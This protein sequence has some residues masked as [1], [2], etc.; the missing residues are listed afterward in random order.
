MLDTLGLPTL[1]DAPAL[2]SGYR[3]ITGH[4]AM[5]PAR[6]ALR[7]L[8]Q[9]GVAIE[10]DAHLQEAVIE[11]RSWEEEHAQDND[12]AEPPFEI[13]LDPATGFAIRERVRR[14]DPRRAAMA[15]SLQSPLAQA[16]YAIGPAD[17]AR[18]FRFRA[19]G[20]NGPDIVCDTRG[21]A[22]L[23]PP[24]PTAP[25]LAV[26]A[27]TR[28]T[29]AQLEAVAQTLDAE[30][31]ADPSRLPRNWLA[32]LRS[33][34]GRAVFSLL[35]SAGGA[36]AP[37]A[38]IALDGT[39]H[40]IGLPGSGK[41]TLI[42][43]LTVFLA[44]HGKRVALLVPSIEFALE[45]EGDLIRY[46][47]PT[48]LLVGQSPDARKRH[49]MRLAE[50]IAMQEGG[51]FGR[52]AP[53]AELLGTRCALAGFLS[54]P[55]TSF[56]FPH[57]QPPCRSLRQPALKKDGSE[58]QEGDRLCPLATSCGRQSSARRLADREAI[59]QIGHIH[60]TDVGLSPH[61]HAE[62]MRHFERIA[63]TCDLV[64]VDEADGAQAAL[65]ERGIAQLAL[66]GAVNSYKSMLLDDVF[67][68]VARGRGLA[69]SSSVENYSLASNRF[70]RLNRALRAHLLQQMNED[71]GVLARFRDAFVTGNSIL[72]ALYL[73][74]NADE[75]DNGNVRFDAIRRFFEKLVRS[76]LVSDTAGDGEDDLSDLD[77]E[78]V[79][80]N[81]AIDLQLSSPARLPLRLSPRPRRTKVQ[82]SA[83]LLDRPVPIPGPEASISPCRFNSRTRTPQWATTCSGST[84]RATR[85]GEFHRAKECKNARVARK[86]VPRCGRA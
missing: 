68:P 6:T 10:S 23:P 41:S 13:S 76:V 73:D 61:F 45:I 2:L 9:M 57:D 35:G 42:F 19:A 65:D 8:R 40:M 44:R 22:P 1:R 16:S 70:M 28:V 3:S 56:E 48:A 50:R 4:P 79:A 84:S 75:D 63:R 78:R 21:I 26:R 51:G 15:A 72:A 24:P 20:D 29:L 82:R 39:A 58:G 27:P 32:R 37:E 85:G 77:L 69:L 7:N 18:S 36:L 81:L 25:D 83:R 54:A 86:F 5:G 17:P 53:G 30:D 60:S 55:P 11:A 46:G 59:V 66:F 64:I 74:P 31:A 33:A 62:R 43:L 38:T 47:V 71:G 14:S 34:D 12:Y 52:T 49:A 67:D 80:R